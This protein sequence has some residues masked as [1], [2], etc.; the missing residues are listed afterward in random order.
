M[1]KSISRPSFIVVFSFQLRTA[2]P[3]IGHPQNFQTEHFNPRWICVLFW[4]VFTD[5][6]LGPTCQTTTSP[7]IHPRRP[8]PPHSPPQWPPSPL[9]WRRHDHEL[10]V[11]ITIRAIRHSHR[12]VSLERGSLHEAGAHEVAEVLGGQRQR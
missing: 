11:A 4:V 10:D 5:V 1:K 8:P 6:T 9:C 2:K 3:G 7:H 12:P